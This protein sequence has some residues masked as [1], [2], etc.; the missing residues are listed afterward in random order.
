[1]LCAGVRLNGAFRRRVIDELLGHPERSVPP[2]LG[3]DLRPVLAH[4]LQARR[5][6][7]R[8]AL[9]A[10]GVWIAF[11]LV[12]F[13]MMWDVMEDEFGRDFQ[14]S[15]GELFVP[16]VFLGKE[17]SLSLFEQPTGWVG[18]YAVTVLALWAGRALLK[19]EAMVFAGRTAPRQPVRSV[20]RR[21][22]GHAVTVFARVLA[23]IYWIGALAVV[24]DNPYAVIFPLLLV[25]VSWLHRIR[26]TSVLRERLSREAFASTPQPE[27]PVNG[28]SWRVGEAI[29]RE[30]HSQA[31]LYD[32]NRPFVGAGVPYKPWSFALEL[33]RKQEMD[34]GMAHQGD[35]QLSS[36]HVIDM[37]TPRIMALR[38]AAAITSRDKLREL[39]IEEVVYLPS[40]AQRG[41][42][43][44]EWDSVW[45]HLGEAVG[46]GGEARRHF[47]RIRLGAWDEQVVLSMFVRVHTQG[48]ILVLEV[49]PHVLGPLAEEFREVDPVVGRRP[50]GALREGALAFVTAP[51]LT[52]A[53]AV[54]ALRSLYSSFRIWLASPDYAAPDAPLVS[55]RELAST[56]ELSLFQ[57]MDMSRYIK[58]IQDRIASGVRDSLE[59]CGFRTDRFEQQIV[60]VSE[61]SLT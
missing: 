11:A 41:S 33:R 52:T 49:A 25:A 60:D 32:A 27:L 46:E 18:F 24:A 44:H 43:V 51:S 42:G 28:R 1:L 15:S 57:E 23:V 38:E 22:I 6:D 12:S 2:S 59:L 47:L 5:Q 3:V 29:D 21:R 61:G 7:V 55:V 40:G 50:S 56:T 37:I 36:R 10:L 14:V 39:E 19:R 17:P 54:S 34:G 9:S 31:T 53:S 16:S 30:Q 48:G 35:M 45:G 4:A 20:T 8:T 58:T 13:L 26:L